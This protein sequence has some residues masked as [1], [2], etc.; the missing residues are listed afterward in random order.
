MYTIRRRISGHTFVGLCVSV[1]EKSTLNIHHKER[2]YMN[3]HVSPFFGVTCQLL[4]VS[5]SYAITIL[6][7]SGNGKLHLNSYLKYEKH[8]PVY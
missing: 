1:V 8:H 3:R 4:F 2:A 6:A 5:K 7:F